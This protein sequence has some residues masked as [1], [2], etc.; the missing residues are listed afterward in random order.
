MIQRCFLFL[1][2]FL[3]SIAN[4]EL[5][6]QT[7][8]SNADDLAD[9]LDAMKDNPRGPFQ[10]IRWFCEDGSILPPKAYACVEHGGG[11]Q[12]GEWSETTRGIRAAGYPIANVLASLGPEDFT[13]EAGYRLLR[14]VL[15]EQFLIDT[16]D[17]WIL[18]QARYYRGAFQ[19]ENEEASAETI[20]RSLAENERWRSDGYPLLV[21]A[22]RLLPD[23][24]DMASA[25]EVRGLAT[26]IN[27]QDPGFGELRNKIHNKPD[28]GD[29]ARVRDYAASR[30][31][32]DLAE[33]YAQLAQG[34]DALNALP[35]P[36]GLLRDL[37]GQGPAAATL[38]A[39]ADKLSATTDPAQR[40]ALLSRAS[41]TIREGFETIGP[42]GK[43]VRSLRLL[44]QLESHLFNEAR[45]VLEA[46][47]STMSRQQLAA[48]AEDLAEGLYGI[49]LLTPHEWSQVQKVAGGLEVN[50]LPLA[51]YRDHLA[52][53]G[54][55]PGWSAR[56]LAFFFEEPVEEFAVLEPHVREY[57]PDRLRGTVLLYYG[58][59]LDLL[60]TDAAIL[61]GATSRLFGQE[62]A[63][64]L[65]ALN[66]GEARGVLRTYDE[67][68]AIAGDTSDSIVIV[69]NTVAELPVV[70]G[71]L[72][73]NEGNAL[74]HVQLLARNLGVPN[75]V[76]GPG[77]LAGLKSR[78]G[79]RVVLAASPGGL[80]DLS[81]DTGND[82]SGA[83]QP[84]ADHRISVDV[85]KLD[86][87]HSGL[88]STDDLTQADSGVRVGPKAAQVGELTRAFP[89]QVAPGLA[90]PFGTFRRMLDQPHDI[91]GGGGP[92][93]FE[94]MIENYD[95]LEGIADPQARAREAR[96]F[97]A[98]L[99][100]WIQTAPMDPAFLDELKSGL[101]TRFGPEGSFG[102]FVRS[103]TNVED[104]AGF[105]G[106]GLNLT[107]P[108][109]VGYAAIVDAIRQVWASPFTDRSY[110]WRQGLMDTPEH[111]YASV[112][113]HQSVNSDR[114]GVMVTA[115]VESGSR[116]W[117][118]LVANEGVGGGV[119]G[120]SAETV[121]VN[122][123]N[124]EVR[125]LN[126]A[127]A[128]RKRV[129]LPEGGSALALA[130]GA[131][132]ILSDGNLADL[133]NFT[134]R[135]PGW[136]KNMPPQE[137]DKAVADVE[138]GFL[139]DRLILFQIRPFV[140]NQ[141]ARANA[142]LQEMDSQ[143]AQTAGRQV[144]MTDR[145]GRG[146]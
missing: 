61:S 131:D 103:D 130:S 7:P 76:V 21:E 22:V 1:L 56:R 32:P 108:N 35:D 92:S 122:R 139:D 140:E 115:D 71:I 78:L 66:P 25:G 127:T 59:A 123:R 4:A 101:E 95:R 48:F 132:R 100:D 34:I 33:Q 124:G 40:V 138:F 98:Q 72:T 54:R 5:V 136:F 63:T 77:L 110:G 82:D 70:A 109:V 39:M 143:L 8:P 44:L 37:K 17:G 28:P 102:V 43:Q 20:L 52:W 27:D 104:L 18:R 16:D 88:I 68:A 118:T 99:R 121:Q 24:S 126:P 111:V 145:P 107:V 89:G 29:A 67:L 86:L 113:L 6:L 137:R 116:D 146:P 10:R 3:T 57:I 129:L 45:R 81:L 11:V 79:E 75:V 19:I 114:S 26:A 93:T 42:P 90:I 62:T 94:W 141:G 31:Q 55:I 120:Q 134:S 47:G 91:A 128:P 135:I 58:Q 74:S 97:L 49:G 51:S 69:P 36:A 117:L 12:H 144:N 64:G 85:D 133:L 83:S 60:A 53:L 50:P 65:R 112:L 15:L 38:H 87:S 9:A 106:A 119:E 2:F 41:A 142:R 46:S 14:F 105:T 84:E 73:E 30:G 80:V 13:G 125:F 23:P 96:T